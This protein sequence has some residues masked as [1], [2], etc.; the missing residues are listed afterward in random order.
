M[1]RNSYTMLVYFL[2]LG[3]WSLAAASGSTETDES[4]IL[5]DT[6]LDNWEK[7]QGLAD[8]IND[9]IEASKTESPTLFPSKS[10]SA[11][12]SNSP[13]LGPSSIPS[14]SL[15]PSNQPST[16]PSDNPSASPTASVLPTTSPSVSPSIVPSNAPSISHKPTLSPS[17]QVSDI[18][19]RIAVCSAR[20]FSMLRFFTTYSSMRSS[21]ISG[22][23]GDTQP[24][25]YSI[26]STKRSPNRRQ[27]SREQ[28][29]Y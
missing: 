29:S 16:E 13:S 1:N 20:V 23:N 25:A 22:S 19:S 11:S 9:K 5:V 27:N 18:E 28:H 26:R 3:S 8:L 4:Q 24:F 7:E 14:S 21:A 17:V 10:P 2:L 6:L 12:P 15:Q